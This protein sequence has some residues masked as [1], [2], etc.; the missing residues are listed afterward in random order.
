MESYPKFHN[1]VG[2]KIVLIGCREFE[3]I[4]DKPP[5][6]HPHV[7]LNIGD[8]SDIVCPYCSTLFRFDPTLGAREADQ[9]NVFTVTSTESK[10]RNIASLDGAQFAELRDRGRTAPF[11]LQI[12]AVA[13]NPRMRGAPSERQQRVGLGPPRRH[14]R[15]ALRRAVRG[16][17]RHGR[18]VLA[19]RWR[20]RQTAARRPY[21][22]Q[23]DRKREFAFFARP[24]ATSGF[25]FDATVR[26]RSIDPVDLIYGH[27]GGLDTCA[28]ALLAAPLPSHIVSRRGS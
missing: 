9:Q 24:E 20:E 22:F 19:H 10:G 2:M 28:R 13:M 21:G 3:C 4:G 18:R 27:I 6:D 17:P 23:R 5:Q 14:I 7:Y 26:R 12:R 1:E 15:A 16:G 8:A 11:A 25:N